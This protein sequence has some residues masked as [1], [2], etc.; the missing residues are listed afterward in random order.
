[1]TRPGDTV[2]FCDLDGTLVL[3]NSFHV[4]IAELLKGCRGRRRLQLGA[5]LA[6]RLSGAAMGGHSGMKRRV[7]EWVGRQP[8]DWQCDIARK[9]VE[10][11]R[12]M[13]SQPVLA[14]LAEYRDR[15]ALVV[16]AT[17]APLVYAGDFA[18][19]AGAN[20][21]L[22]TTSERGVFSEP[23]R[24]AKADACAL[25]MARQ[26]GRQ[27][28]RHIVAITDHADDLPLLRMADHAVLQCARSHRQGILHALRLD[29]ETFDFIDPVEAEEG[30]G[31]WLWFDDRHVGPIDRWE[32]RMLLSKHRHARIFTGQ[33]GWRKIG[34]G[35]PLEPA[36]LRNDCPLPPT[37]RQRLGYAIRRR[38]LR[39]WLGIFH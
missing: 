12:P 32:V 36:V 37:M 27:T 15:G 29:G 22:A 18:A 19:I 7:L 17:A 20:D 38:V 23:I 11:L 16:L 8:E 33:G 24:E 31:Y 35:E 6:T 34:P 28:F 13:L 21:V 10:A 25:W 3:N 5:I 26:G 39:D 1:M 14:R 30:G 9:T 4:F 2:V